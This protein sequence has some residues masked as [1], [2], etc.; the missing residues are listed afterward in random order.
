MMDQRLS[1][2]AHLELVANRIRKMMW[3][4]KILRHIADKALITKVYVALAESIITYCITIWGGA[5]KTEFLGVERAQRSLLKVI[6]LKRYRFSTAELYSVA[7]VLSVRKLYVLYT[8]LKVH[9]SITYDPSK[10]AKR[11]KHCVVQ[12]VPTKTA[13]ARRQY[14]RLSCHLYNNIN[15][16]L[17]IYARNSHDCKKTV[18]NWIMSLG[19][20]EVESLLQTIV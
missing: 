4:F 15:E 16:I 8:I 17:E 9:K 5:A 2:Y 1:W 3:I 12:S 10:L 7:G 19:Y 11:R 13:F 20:E 14:Y 6:H 18:K